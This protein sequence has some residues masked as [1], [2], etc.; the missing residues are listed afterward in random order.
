[1]LKKSPIFK[2]CFNMSF[3]FRSRKW[4]LCS[5]SSD[6]SCVYIFIILCVH[7]TRLSHLVVFD[8][9]G[10]FPLTLDEELDYVVLQFLFI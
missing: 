7:A 2:M 8:L 10:A 3:S 1:M 4:F 5:K 6:Q 9:M